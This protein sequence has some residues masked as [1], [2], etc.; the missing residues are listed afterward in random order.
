[1][2]RDSL[3]GNAGN[4]RG[5][6]ARTTERESAIVSE[7]EYQDDGQPADDDE[8]GSFGEPDETANGLVTGTTSAESADLAD[9]ESGEE[10]PV[11]AFKAELR[12]LPGD[13]YVVHSYAGYENR[14]RAN[15]ESRTQSLNMEEYIFRSR[16]QP[17]R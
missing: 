4:L 9:A 5:S 15:L 3:A 13:W 7:S 1:M 8:A 16:C 2:R 6:P 12:R 17:T 10:D 14:V 11:A